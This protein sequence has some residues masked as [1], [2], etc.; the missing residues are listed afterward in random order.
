MTFSLKTEQ[1]RTANTPISNNL[2]RVGEH[3]RRIRQKA[4]LTFGG[5]F[6]FQI[7]D[8]LPEWCRNELSAVTDRCLA[9][10]PKAIEVVQ[11]SFPQ[12]LF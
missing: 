8:Q 3:P 10:V 2:A 6:N 12:G 9:S 5:T 7:L 11:I 4:F 1:N